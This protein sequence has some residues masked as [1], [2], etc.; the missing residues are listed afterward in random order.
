MDRTV[1]GFRPGLDP[2]QCLS[3]NSTFGRALFCQGW[4]NC[5]LYNDIIRGY[6]C[7]PF[8]REVRF[9]FATGGAGFCLS[10]RLAEKMA[11]W[12]RYF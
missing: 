5:W 3:E 9:W 8:Q 12:A 7:V 11:P 10:R 1:S 6:V 2:I 4:A